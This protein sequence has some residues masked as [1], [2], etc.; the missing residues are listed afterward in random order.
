MKISI[1][2]KKCLISRIIQLSLKYYDDSKKQWLV[3]KDE[4]GGVAI[5]EFVGLKSKMYSVLVGNKNV[6]ST[7]SNNAYKDVLLNDKYLR[8]QIIEK[9]LMKS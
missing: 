4:G 9:E 3:Y 1:R 6:V 2:V 8:H 7:I 5:E